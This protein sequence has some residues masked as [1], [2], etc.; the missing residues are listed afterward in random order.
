LDVEDE[1]EADYEDEDADADDDAED[2]AEDT[3]DV[4]VLAAAAAA[5]AAECRDRE[6]EE[7]RREPQLR[8]AV[9]GCAASN[10]LMS[11]LCWSCRNAKAVVQWTALASTYSV[12]M[13]KACAIGSIN[14]VMTLDAH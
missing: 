2:E 10:V 8:S 14:R 5:A 9:A 7:E 1:E 3:A 4:V 13:P 11:P 12:A 6:R